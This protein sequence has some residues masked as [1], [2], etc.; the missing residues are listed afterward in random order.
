MHRL[1]KLIGYELP[2]G[3]VRHWKRLRGLFALLSFCK[4]N[5]T[6]LQAL[7]RG[8]QQRWI[9]VDRRKVKRT[10]FGTDDQIPMYVPV[11]G[12]PTIRQIEVIRENLPRRCFG[13]TIEE[14]I[15]LG[16]LVNANLAAS[17]IELPLEWQPKPIS[18]SLIEWPMYD[19]VIEKF[20][21]IKICPSTMRPYA[22]LSNGQS[23]REGLR[24]VLGFEIEN[25]QIFSGHRWL[26]S[27]SI[28]LLFVVNEHH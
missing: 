14:L 9:Y 17:A 13:L 4:W 18:E 12:A 2:D 5:N 23:W 10:L 8:L 11:D 20:S 27:F 25:G 1:I 28:V 15:G 16:K 21:E 22:R 3:V 26:N 24:C 7:I 6:D 19:G